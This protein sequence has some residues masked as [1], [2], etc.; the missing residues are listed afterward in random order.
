M[1]RMESR[2]ALIVLALLATVA[3]SSHAVTRCVANNGQYPCTTEPSYT[4]VRAALDAQLR[5][6]SPATAHH[7]HGERSPGDTGAAGVQRRH[8]STMGRSHGDGLA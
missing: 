8:G 2:T 3:D 4:T 7:A 1:L 6:H 5:D